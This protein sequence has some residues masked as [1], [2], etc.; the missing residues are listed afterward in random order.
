MRTPATSIQRGMMGCMDE[1]IHLMEPISCAICSKV[2]DVGR[3][4]LGSYGYHGGET[5]QHVLDDVTDILGLPRYYVSVGSSLPS[6]VFSAAA[7]RIGVPVGSMPEICEAI[8]R[9]AGRTY[10]PSFDSRASLSG[11]GSTVTLEGFQEMRSALKTFLSPTPP[12]ST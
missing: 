1:C 4:S 9:K 2:S 6:D 5:K 11:G 8:V 10:S 7:R 12:L 3:R